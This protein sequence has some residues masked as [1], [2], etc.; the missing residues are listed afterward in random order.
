MATGQGSGW[1]RGGWRRAL[2]LAL[3]LGLS[4]GA[5]LPALAFTIDDGFHRCSNSPSCTGGG[6]LDV[7]RSI[8]EAPRW[9]ASPSPAVGS[10]GL[11]DGIQVSIAPGFAEGLAPTPD[12]LPALRSAVEAGFRA[13]ETAELR[14][15]LRWDVAG[16]RGAALG[17]EI[18][19]FLV[20]SSFPA[21]SG[22]SA[23]GITSF[24]TR[25]LAD[26]S[27]TSGE[28]LPGHAMLG[29]DIFVAADRFE[30]LLSLLAVGGFATEADRE[31][32]LTNLV[33]HELGHALGLDHPNEFPYANL[34]TDGDPSTPIVVDPA[35]PFAGLAVSPNLDPNAIMRGGF[36]PDPRALLYTALRADDVSGRDVLYPSRVPEPGTALLL[37]LGLAGLSRT[38][39]RAAR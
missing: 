5:A 34:D 3:A 28:S 19:L 21:F 29:S 2:G 6:T 10:A 23:T 22:N 24:A 39:G 18:D 17:A 32:R 27:L 13:W 25:F 26:R 30:F 1:V 37:A 15:D 12:R 33:M 38:R 36:P 20:D 35:H 31:A 9:T 14:F 11:Y 16:V 4:A 8:A 7:A